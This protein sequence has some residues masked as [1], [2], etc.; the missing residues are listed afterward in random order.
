[1]SK[2]QDNSSVNHT[3]NGVYVDVDPG[4]TVMLLTSYAFAALGLVIGLSGCIVIAIFRDRP[5]MKMSQQTL[6]GMFSLGLAI[7]NGALIPRIL[8]LSSPRSV[9][10]I[11]F[12]VLFYLAAT[13]SLAC[14][15][16]KEFRA[17]IVFKRSQELKHVKITD[18]QVYGVLGG[19]VGGMVV[20]LIIWL[21]LFPPSPDPCTDYRCAS[22]SSALNYVAFAYII[23]LTI[24][25]VT[26]AILARKVNAVAAESTGI[27]VT[28]SLACCAIV[29]LGIII[30][31]QSTPA[32]VESW[33]LSFCV[34]AISIV[35]VSLIVFRKLSWIDHTEEDLRDKFLGGAGAKRNNN[36]STN[37]SIPGEPHDDNSSYAGPYTAPPNSANTSN[38]MAGSSSSYSAARPIFVTHDMQLPKPEPLYNP[39]G[40]YGSRMH[41]PNNDAASHDESTS[42]T[43]LSDDFFSNRGS[44]PNTQNEPS[45]QFRPMV[46]TQSYNTD[47]GVAS[48]KTSRSDDFLS[49]RSGPSTQNEP[50]LV[51]FTIPERRRSVNTDDGASSAGTVRSDDASFS[52]YRYASSL[53]SDPPMYGMG[54]RTRS[55]QRDDGE[56]SVMTSRSDE[57]D[58]LSSSRS[59]PSLHHRQF[60]AQQPS[61]QFRFPP[62]NTTQQRSNTDDAPRVNLPPLY[63]RPNGAG[64]KT[65]DAPFVAMPPFN[66]ANHSRGGSQSSLTFLPTSADNAS[67]VSHFANLGTEDDDDEVDGVS[68][69]VRA[70][71][72]EYQKKGFRIG[73]IGNW[74]EYLDRGTGEQYFLNILTGEVSD[75]APEEDEEDA[76]RKLNS[77]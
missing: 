13:F 49:T 65:D 1:M 51:H 67:L 52:S 48:M 60:N 9:D 21:V 33:L 62:P 27:L 16:V 59:A 44:A 46:R 2:D 38:S 35:A 63:Q 74:E 6:L 69:E 56:A 50:P 42:A 70:K 3:C 29:F 30:K 43:A 57:R 17:W 22:S 61:V 76:G 25:T 11:V 37:S 41:G 26:V 36:N 54:D 20:I 58:F 8:S 53:H 12:D 14:L 5:A 66:R 47:D 7:L 71:V 31:T 28:A 10:C 75:H 23:V 55:A 64:S 18:L 40:R 39:Y 24:L 4:N 77:V 45:V 34:A 72:E 68:E 15:C 32:Y 19:I 73:E